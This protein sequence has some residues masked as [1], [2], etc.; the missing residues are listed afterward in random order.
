MK[1]VGDQNC[2]LAVDVQIISWQTNGVLEWHNFDSDFI[3]ILTCFLFEFVW[4][5]FFKLTL[6]TFGLKIIDNI[7]TVIDKFLTNF[8]N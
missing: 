3:E 6:E 4:N 5:F 1:L 7:L 2:L 8:S